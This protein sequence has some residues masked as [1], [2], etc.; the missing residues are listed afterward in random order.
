MSAFNVLT[1]QAAVP[2]AGEIDVVIEVAADQEIS[3]DTHVE[4][5]GPWQLDLFEGTVV[6]AGGVAMTAQNFDRASS[7]TLNSNFLLG[8]AIAPGNEGALLSGV[9]VETYRIERLHRIHPWILKAGENYLLRLTNH[10][11]GGSDTILSIEIDEFPA[12]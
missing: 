10:T 1:R 3:L 5:E 6:G 4:A 9:N 12:R 8:P 11:G 2:N 7:E